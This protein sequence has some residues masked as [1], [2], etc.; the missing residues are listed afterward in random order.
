MKTIFI[1]SPDHLESIFQESTKYSFDIQ[2]YGNC[3]LAVKKLKYVNASNLLGFAY[4]ADK[5]PVA[6]TSDYQ[7]LDNFMKLSNLMSNGTKFVMITKEPNDGIAKIAKKY[8]NL[9]VFIH[10]VEAQLTDV[11]INKN[12]FGS[13]LLANYE[14][15]KFE[16]EKK[17]QIKDFEI[18][19]LKFTPVIQGLLFDLFSAVHTGTELEVT[20]E[21]DP[22]MRQYKGSLFGDIRRVVIMKE[23][24]M[25]YSAELEKINKEIEKLDGKTMGIFMS[26][27]EQLE[28]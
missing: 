10:K 7:D 6:G 3:A 25:D 15:Y 24:R 23:H 4:V 9:E 21:N 14:P 11:D 19:T 12:L 27:L 8:R 28:E 22:L 13:I 5:L 2:G 18:P 20:M 17:P 16:E 1:V 26:L